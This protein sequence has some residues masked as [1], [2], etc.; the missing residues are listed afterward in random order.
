MGARGIW[1]IDLLCGIARPTVGIITRVEGVH[2]ELF[3][4]IESVARAKGELVEALPV[5]GLAVLNADDERVAAMASR[6]DAG[7]LTFG[8]SSSSD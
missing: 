2:L 1:H 5:D 7:V 4:D 6:T 8:L 3:G